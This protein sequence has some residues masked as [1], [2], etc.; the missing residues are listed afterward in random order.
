LPL[1]GEERLLL[2]TDNARLWDQPGFSGDFAHITTGGARYLVEKGIKLIGIDYLSIERFHGNGEVH[3]FL[4]DNG[5][6][7]L[8]GLNL[9]GIAAGNYEL[10]C[11]PLKIR[12]DDGAPVR[13]VLRTMERAGFDPATT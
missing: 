13:A 10:I 7:I 1:E 6:V 3:R 11:L 4:L 2:K 9:A 8:E 12:G 5:V